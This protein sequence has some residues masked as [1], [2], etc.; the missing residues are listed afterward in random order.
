MRT[1]VELWLKNHYKNVGCYSI[2]QLLLLLLLNNYQ[3]NGNN[4][5]SSVSAADSIKAS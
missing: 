3:Y 2:F 1:L 5:I 4:T